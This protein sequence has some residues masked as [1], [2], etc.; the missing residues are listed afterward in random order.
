MKVWRSIPRI[1]G[2]SNVSKNVT[3]IDN[4][5]GRKTAEPI[6]VRVVMHLSSGA[7]DVDDLT[8][9]WVGSNA[10]DN[11]IRCAE[12]RRAALSKDVDALM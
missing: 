3:G 11:P 5:S 6:E 12:D 8:A 4:V 1:A 2:I 9:E 7:E 10:H